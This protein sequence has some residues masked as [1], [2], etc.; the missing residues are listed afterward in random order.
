MLTVIAVAVISLFS[1]PASAST[2][3]KA[4]NAV[5]V[6]HLPAGQRVGAHES[7]PAGQH[8]QRAPGYDRSVVGSGVG[9]EAETSVISDAAES[10]SVNSF[11]GATPVLM[12][13]GTEEPID[14]I[15]VGDKV[16][17]TDPQTGKTAARPVTN[18]IVHSGEHTM[19]DVTLAD[20]SMLTATDHHPF[21]DATTGSFVYAI[22]LHV[23]DQVREDNGQ[24]ITITN[25]QTFEES[26]TAYNLTVDG[27]HTYYAGTTPVL[28][29]NSCLSAADALQDPAALEGLTPSQ[30]DDLA[31]NAGYD[32]LPGKAGAANPA[33]RYYVPGTNG[34]VGF[35]VLPSGVAGQAG[36]KGG[37]YLRFF[38][39]PNAG[40][41]IPLASS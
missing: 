4:Q 33:T 31:T 3:S 17:A 15:K 29:H 19:V 21:W 16:L 11:T 24:L 10:C 9:A 41:R 38:G 27:I 12:A 14:K 28:V 32:T 18:I 39:G 5:G 37:A 13:N 40:L 35:R 20:G 2:L 6:I 25:V 23:G 7:I 36:I 26:V 34:S 1:A 8:R 22:D 30:I